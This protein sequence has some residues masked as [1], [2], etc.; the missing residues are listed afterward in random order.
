MED[1]AHIPVSLSIYAEFI[2][3]CVKF[4]LNAKDSAGDALAEYMD[5]IKAQEGNIPNGKH[6]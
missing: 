3:F 4:G 6:V 5:R 1:A 2:R